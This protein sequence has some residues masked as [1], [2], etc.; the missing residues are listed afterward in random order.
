MMIS[1]EQLEDIGKLCLFYR[2]PDYSSDINFLAAHFLLY[3]GPL[4]E[5]FVLSCNY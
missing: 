5:Q 3:F 2:I 4:F 1:H